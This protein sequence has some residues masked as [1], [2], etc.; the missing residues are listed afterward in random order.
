MEELMQTIKT[1]KDN[2]TEQ[3]K[4]I[5]NICL[6]IA[7]NSPSITNTTNNN[8]TIHVNYFSWAR[9]LQLPGR[10]FMLIHHT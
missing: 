6:A 7:K 2:D 3:L 8:T 4:Q 5:T 9:A 1:L 10:E